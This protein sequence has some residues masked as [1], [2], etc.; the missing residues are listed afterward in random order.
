MEKA[1]IFTADKDGER[2][3]AFCARVVE[4]LSRARAQALIRAGNVQV[5]QSNKKPNTRLNVGD[6]VQILL[7][8]AESLAVTPEDIPLNILYED[9][10]FIVINKA[11][12]MVVHPAP[13]AE[14]GT[15]VHALLYHCQDLSGINGVLR[16]GIVHR[17]DKDT[18]GVMV[19][20]KNDQ[21]HRSLAEQI[22]T[23]KAQRTYLAIVCG[24]IEEDSAV[25]RGAIGRS[26][27][28]RKKM[29]IR[30]QVG[31][32][33]ETAF[34]V[35][36][37]FTAH[38]L[39]ECKLKT[40]RTHQIRV[41]MQYIGHPVLCDPKYG[42]EDMHFPIHGQ[43]LHSHT[44]TLNHPRTGERM[45]FVAE[46]PEDMQACLQILRQGIVSRR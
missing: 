34:R 16:P 15:L 5:Q 19:V 20:A 42:R 43:A 11:R 2:L 1:R 21:A 30:P 31:K 6:E 4:N 22:R 12:G 7:P 25:I 39:V 18:S 26:E 28:D 44:L 8:A 41:H 13:G 29:A 23:K 45:K 40:G 3:D 37:R 38:T 36:E 35:C 10:D 17:L 46:L 33:A 24:V 27:K 9:R 32:E 14:T